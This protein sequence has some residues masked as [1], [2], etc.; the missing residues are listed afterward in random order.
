MFIVPAVKNTSRGRGSGGLVT[1]WDKGLTK[2]VSKINCSNHRLQAT[3][4]S[5]PNVPILVL[6]CYFPCDPR[7]DNL[8]ETELLTLLA[9]IRNV[10]NKASCPNVFLAGDLN[11]HFNRFSRFTS[12]V[13]DFLVEELGLTIMWENPDMDPDHMV[14]QVDYTHLHTV[15]DSSHY[16]TIDHFAV[17]PQVYQVVS[18]AGVLHCGSNP[19][20]HSAIFAKVKV[21]DLDLELET[22]IPE[23]RSSWSKAS[24][25]AKSYFQELLVEKLDKISAKPELLMC[26]DL[27]CKS[28]MENLE[29][30]TIDVMESIEEAAKLALPQTGGSKIAKKIPIAGWTEY[31]KPFKIES[32]FWFSTWLSAGKPE[33]GNI[34]NNM[35]YSKNQYKFAVRR[36]KRAQAKVQNDK[37]VS[38]IINGGV[39]IFSEIRKF[40]GNSTSIS[41][42]IDNEVGSE[43]IAN[44]FATIYSEL[45]NRVQLDEK[46]EKISETIE[47]D[48]D[49]ECH[50]QL[51][52]INEELINKAMKLMKPSKCDAV[53]DVMSDFLINAPPQLAIHLA[54]LVKLFLSHG[55]LP[56]SILVC[57]LLPLVKDNLGD[58][59]SSDNYRAIAGG[60]L[61]LKLVDLVILLLEGDRLSCDTLQ[62]GYQANSSTTMCTW[63]VTSIIDYYNRNGRPVYGCAMDM[64]KAFDMVEW[65]QLFVKLKDRG[66]KPIFLRLLISI[67][68]NQKCDVKWAGKY[69]SCFSVSNGVRQGAISSA[70]LF[71][72]YIDELF[73]ILRNAGFGC[74][75]NGLFLGCFGYADDIFLI[76]GSRSGLQAMVNICQD[77][78]SS[79][80]LQFSTNKD[81]EKSKTKCL[82]FSKKIKERKDVLPYQ[83]KW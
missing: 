82:V 2:Y 31:V 21:R 26:K 64:S 9:D 36:L 39:N 60:C 32:Q 15:K 35:K 25:D 79:K 55:A 41:S 3:K 80:N 57:T 10:T 44:H 45:Y 18:E 8:D 53:F 27:H 51:D 61:L 71:S 28:H 67:Y 69:S 56:S 54:S 42:R 66:V 24:E 13:K 72:V 59:T 76:S 73:I 70:I 30:Y 62:F 37:F 29:S 52:R 78:A 48:I 46:L 11:C 50:L 43:N 19:S 58:I 47:R 74:H 77:F 6:N 40:R 1:L 7:T 4:F 65:G 34:Y 83:A 14:Q 17:S 23:K 5:L 63:T 16:S 33:V 81:P 68:R 12:I 22:S 20:N 49:K 38:S 75:I